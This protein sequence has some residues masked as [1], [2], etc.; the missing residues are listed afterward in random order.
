MKIMVVRLWTLL[1]LNSCY[2]KRIELWKFYNK[3]TTKRQPTH[4]IPFYI[5]PASRQKRQKQQQKKHSAKN[6][7][8]VD[9]TQTEPNKKNEIK[10]KVCCF[11]LVSASV[12]VKG[13]R[14]LSGLTWRN[15]MIATEGE[16]EAKEEKGCEK[17]ILTLNGLSG[18]QWPWN[19][20]FKAFSNSSP[21][22]LTRRRGSLL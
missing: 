12:A 8:N 13:E 1:L 17:S 14:E 3:P 11:M 2:I 21:K 9:L 4:F 22:M 18:Y 5:I 7:D 16:E 6:N 20:C 10:Q 19:L 15:K